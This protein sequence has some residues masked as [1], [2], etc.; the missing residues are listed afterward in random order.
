VVRLNVIIGGPDWVDDLQRSLPPGRV[1]LFLFDPLRG[2]RGSRYDPGLR[3]AVRGQYI[4]TNVD[5]SVVIEVA[6]RV[7]PQRASEGP[8]SFLVALD[9]RPFDEVVEEVRAAVS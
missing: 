3:E 2:S 8:P 6:G 1:L 9:G 7:A 5:Q 4:L